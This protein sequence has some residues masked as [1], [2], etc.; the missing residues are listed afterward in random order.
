MNGVLVAGSAVAVAC[1]GVVVLIVWHAFTT[2][3]HVPYAPLLSLILV[4]AFT[5]AF[6][7]IGFTIGYWMGVE[8]HA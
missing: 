1:L 3:H 7:S 8:Y 5:I 6:L 4:A 2:K